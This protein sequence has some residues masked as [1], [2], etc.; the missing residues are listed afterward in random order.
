MLFLVASPSPLALSSSLVVSLS[1]T[2]LIVAG[3]GR[4]CIIHPSIMLSSSSLARRPLHPAS[5]RSPP[6]SFIVLRLPRRWRLDPTS[7]SWRGCQRKAGWHQ[8]QLAD[9][10]LNGCFGDGGRSKVVNLGCVRFISMFPA[11]SNIADVAGDSC[12]DVAAA[13]FHVAAMSPRCRRQHS[14][15]PAISIVRTYVP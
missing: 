1:H 2:N 8:V 4:T 15:L 3:I 14:M 11:I 12:H 6:L 10:S 5:P 13:T 9:V 7:N